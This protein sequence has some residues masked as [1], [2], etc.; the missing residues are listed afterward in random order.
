M[1]PWPELKLQ[2]DRLAVYSLLLL[3]LLFFA[4]RCTK[5]VVYAKMLR[6]ASATHF[7]SRKKKTMLAT[8]TAM[9]KAA[10]TENPNQKQIL[11][12]Q[13]SATMRP[14]GTMPAARDVDVVG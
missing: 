7:S 6:V 8:G 13:I 1:A 3:L 2:L 9:G 11:L 12:Q 10:A 4:F 5:K 14:S